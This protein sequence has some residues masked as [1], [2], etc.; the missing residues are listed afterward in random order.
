MILENNIPTMVYVPVLVPF[1][2]IPKEDPMEVD[3]NG[4]LLINTHAPK[5]TN[6]DIWLS[7][8]VEVLQQMTDEQL[9]S[10]RNFRINHRKYGNV[11][12][13]GTVDLRDLDLDT[14]IDFSQTNLK[15]YPMDKD[16]PPVGV[17]LNKL[18]R[19]T[20]FHVEPKTPEEKNVKT[21]YFV[22]RLQRM[23]VRQNTTFVAYRPIRREWTFDVS[24][25]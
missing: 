25:W 4:T 5:Q 10:V 11:F 21:G 6:P 3:A 9:A 17:G 23:C 24:K 14:I 15:V 22:N 18:C 19:V 1:M 2:S 8:S 7:P 13:P 16:L 12:W 20:L